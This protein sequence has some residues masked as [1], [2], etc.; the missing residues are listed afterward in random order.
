MADAHQIQAMGALVL[1][2]NDKLKT[3]KL[4]PRSTISG[5][6]IGLILAM[7]TPIG[8]AVGIIG[9]GIFGA[10]HHKSLIIPKDDR[11]RL[12]HELQGDKAALA[13]ITDKTGATGI[14]DE[15]ASLGGAP[16]VHALDDAAL[17]ELDDATV[18]ANANAAGH[19][20]GVM[21]RTR[22]PDDPSYLCLA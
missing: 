11:G 9:G 8:M 2:E 19:P 5:A 1:D 13:V 12:G 10:L 15:L 20:V 21:L 7:L 3:E 17:A 22:Q 6:G 4:G 18:A 16:E 14:S